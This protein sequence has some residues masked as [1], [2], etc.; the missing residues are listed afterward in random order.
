MPQRHHQIHGDRRGNLL[1]LAVRPPRA[2]A[3][4]GEISM[5]IEKVSGRHKAVIHSI[6]GV[7]SGE[8]SGQRRDRGSPQDDR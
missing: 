2:C 6:S 5:A 8:F 4:L 1:E 7:Y 3:S